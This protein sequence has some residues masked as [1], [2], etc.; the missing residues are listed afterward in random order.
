MHNKLRETLIGLQ[1]EEVLKS[2]MG[3]E[4]KHSSK[5]E[6]E[7][8]LSFVNDSIENDVDKMLNEYFDQKQK[9]LPDRKRNNTMMII[10]TT[11]TIILTGL[12]GYVINRELWT[13]VVIIYVI[14]IIVQS[15][16]YF[17]DKEY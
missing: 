15:I 6:R 9:N 5:E 11:L 2:Y 1:Q 4:Y 14:L 12:S 3:D 10:Y 16:P 8:F 13:I 17:S 7:H